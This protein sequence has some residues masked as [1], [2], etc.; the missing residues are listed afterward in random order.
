[1]RDAYKHP[2][3][4]HDAQIS[5][6]TKAVE[7]KKL[8]HAWLLSGPKGI[9][10]AHFAWQASAAVLPGE[11][12]EEAQASPASSHMQARSHPAFRWVEPDPGK[13]KTQITIDQ[14][15]AMAGM[16]VTTAGMGGWRIAV[17]DAADEMNRSAANAVLKLLEEPTEKSLFFLIT[18]AAGRLLPTIRSR[19]SVLRFE[20]LSNP[21]TADLLSHLAPD[22]DDAERDA[23]LAF[24]HGSPG[25]ARDL[26]SGNAADYVVTLEDIFM[27]L[28]TIDET[29]VLGLADM[30]GDR[31]AP[32]AFSILWELIEERIMFAAKAS[33]SGEK[34]APWVEQLQTSDWIALQESLAQR[35]AQAIGLNLSP[36]QVVLSLFF[37]IGRMAQV[38][39]AA[40]QY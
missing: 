30:L 19:C 15:R 7:S 27:S 40:T 17:I 28:P 9:G 3:L 2:L 12:R 16:F 8:H 38:A 34:G 10:K 1:M 35:K 23:V 24:A 25:R 18:H 20:P 29:A 32:P 14:I 5:A 33:I 36:R 13:A 37:D 39:R 4:G 22:T 31:T 21:Q 11:Q 6:F 26:L